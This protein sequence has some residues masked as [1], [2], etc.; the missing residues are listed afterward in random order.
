[1]DKFDQIHCSNSNKRCVKQ[2]HNDLICVLDKQSHYPLLG[3]W[4][5]VVL[6]KRGEKKRKQNVNNSQTIVL[7]KNKNIHR[8]FLQVVEDI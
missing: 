6:T 2:N 3:R 5:F 1:M 7:C 4:F 8:F